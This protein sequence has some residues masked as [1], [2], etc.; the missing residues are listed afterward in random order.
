MCEDAVYGSIKKLF[1][2]QETTSITFPIEYVVAYLIISHK[3][4][5]QNENVTLKFK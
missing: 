2:I 5:K 3:I 1:K 4:W